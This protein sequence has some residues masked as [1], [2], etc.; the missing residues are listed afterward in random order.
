MCVVREIVRVSG[1]VISA[2]AR[3]EEEGQRKE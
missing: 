1:N 3:R 2:V